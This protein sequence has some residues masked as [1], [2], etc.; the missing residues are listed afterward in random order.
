ME[1]SICYQ[2]SIAILSKAEG[3]KLDATSLL[4]STPTHTPSIYISK[5][6]ILNNE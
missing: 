2:K 5:W 1:D 4:S 3:G 6:R